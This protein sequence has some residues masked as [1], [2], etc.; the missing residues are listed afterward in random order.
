MGVPASGLAKPDLRI[1]NPTS[2]L[3]RRR[4]DAEQTTPYV[5]W[6]WVGTSLAERTLV[7]APLMRGDTWIIVSGRSSAASAVD[8]QM[9]L[10]VHDRSIPIVPELPVMM[11]CVHET[12]AAQNLTMHPND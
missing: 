12:L 2:L 7:I 11:G 3:R 1:P 6:G 5:I 10:E 9:S 4:R 8:A